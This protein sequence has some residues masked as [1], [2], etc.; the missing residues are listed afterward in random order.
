MDPQN[1]GQTVA[2]RSAWIDSQMYGFRRAIE[3]FGVDRFRKNCIKAVSGFNHV[4]SILYPSSGVSLITSTLGTYRLG[5]AS[6]ETFKSKARLAG[7]IA[8]ER[9]GSMASVYAAESET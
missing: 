9:A 1:K 7:E 2:S 5:E 8:K 6:T 4:L 3:G